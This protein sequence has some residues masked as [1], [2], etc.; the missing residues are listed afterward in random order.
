MKIKVYGVFTAI[1]HGINSKVLKG[2]LNMKVVKYTLTNFKH[3][4][5]AYVSFR[6]GVEHSGPLHTHD[7]FEIF[8]VT[9]GKALHLI[10]GSVQSL[11]V[12]DLVLIRPSDIHKYDFL[13][14]SDFK[15]INFP[16]A[17]KA[18]SYISSIFMPD[19]SIA[20][21]LS[22]ELPPTVNINKTD[23]EFI[24]KEISK[25]EKLKHGVSNEYANCYFRSLL[26]FIISRH[27]LQKRKKKTDVPPWL[28]STV[29]QMQLVENFSVGFSKM[30]ELSNCSQQ[31]L[32]RV[33]KKYYHTTP[34]K[35][36]N[37]LRLDYAVYLLCNTEEEILTISEQSGFGNLSHFYH[38]FKERY[39]MSPAKF[40]SQRLSE[41]QL[42]SPSGKPVLNKKGESEELSLST[43][44]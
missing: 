21:L 30:T 33:F 42:G 27:F 5:L 9:E 24:I 6:N 28:S 17:T 32:C 13:Q 34:M 38:L 20:E 18:I 40:R 15:F 35:F 12:G 37:G 16:F 7:F 26:A 44:K 2:Y 41:P 19:I 11:F 31:H 10:N 23:S 43:G 39:E 22:A 1:I 8:L 4:D 3:T 36:I 14:S 25:A 29:D